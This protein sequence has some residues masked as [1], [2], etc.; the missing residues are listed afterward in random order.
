MSN[1]QETGG[2]GGAVERGRSGEKEPPG[3]RMNPMC[4]GGWVGEGR[5]RR[6]EGGRVK[7]RSRVRSTDDGGPR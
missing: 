1:R 7:R 5:E 2:N 3:G 4:K 6:G